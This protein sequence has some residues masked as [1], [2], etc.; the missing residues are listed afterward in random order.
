MA[1]F[2]LASFVANA[3][4]LFIAMKHNRTFYFFTCY[5][6]F[7]LFVLYHSY[8]L[9]LL[10]IPPVIYC[11][12]YL[13]ETRDFAHIYYMKQ[14]PFSKYVLMNTPQM[15]QPYK[16]PFKPFSGHFLTIYQSQQEVPFSV[17]YTRK[18]ITSKL[19]GG[20]FALD[21]AD[22]ELPKDSPIL[23]ILPGMAG[24]SQSVYVKKLCTLAIE[25]K[26]QPVVMIQR[27]C[28]KLQLKTGR[29]HNAVVLD[30]IMQAIEEINKDYPNVPINIIGYSLGGALAVRLSYIESEKLIPMNVVAIG[31]ICPFWGLSA[32]DMPVLYSQNIMNDYKNLVLKNKELF[33]DC[34]KEGNKIDFKKVEAAKTFREVEESVVVPVF[35]YDNV[36]QYYYESEQW[37]QNLPCT[38]IPTYSINA[39]DDPVCCDQSYSY[40]RLK[41]LAG[42]SPM[43]IASYNQ[44]GGHCAFQESLKSNSMS[45]ADRNVLSFFETV[46]KMKK[47]G[48]LD[49][50]RKEISEKFIWFNEK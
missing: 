40:L 25:Q 21:I 31:S 49:E 4:T 17:S 33:K 16:C 19:D 29:I 23:Y 37:F 41:A 6:V 45:Y 18:E 8:P 47:D 38:H 2:Y 39:F 13:L 27:G 20:V 11:L 15:L 44:R 7:T 22:T 30:D 12:L 28:G 36:E 34:G 32:L 9:V 46:L 35:G 26:M 24:D 10:V 5:V 43:F 14:S 42:F 48:K 50:I 1:Q 3:Q